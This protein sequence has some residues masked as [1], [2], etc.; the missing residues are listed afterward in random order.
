MEI[1]FE[2]LSSVQQK[3]RSLDV[4]EFFPSVTKVYK[5]FLNIV[6][7]IGIAEKMSYY[8]KR[9]LGIFN[10]LNFFQLLAGLLIPILGLVH[11]DDV[12]FSAWLLACLPSTI[13][14]CSLLFNYQRKHQAALLCYFILY[15]FF[16]GFVYLQGLNAG[17]ELNFILYGVLAVFFLQDIGYMLFAVALS[18]INYFVLAIMLSY[19]RYDVRHEFESLFFLNHIVSL[20]FIIYGLYL[21]KKENSIYQLRLKHKQHELEQKNSEINEQKQVIDDKVTLLEK[22]TAELAELNTLKTKLFSVVSHDLRSPM[23]ALRNLFKNMHQK[24]TPAQEI[25]NVMPDVLMDLNYTIGL[26]ENL[27]QWSKTQMQSSAAKPQEIEVSKMINEVL[28]L[29]HLQ[30]EAKQIYIENKNNAPVFVYADKDMVN[31]ILRNILSNA[32]KFTPNQGYIE[33]GV[34]EVSSFVEIYVQ[35]TG[36]GISKDAIQ[37][38]NESNFYTTKGTSSE[39]GTGLGLMLCKE[40]LH[41]NGGQMHIESEPGRG[42]MF[43]FTLPRVEA[44]D[45]E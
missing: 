5:D 11:K 15:P 35:D 33:V 18:M 45:D 34:N 22:Q 41:K 39:S 36:V 10:Q 9:K 2:K 37:K 7:S 8:E 26:M 23:Y 13:S 17:I 1:L 44:E 40:F 38:I 4:S 3:I 12:P 27:L 42:S 24:N 32:I 25:K 29:L 31:L 21:I 43:S 6:R 14:I 30:A 28:Q 20:C 19:F 16:T